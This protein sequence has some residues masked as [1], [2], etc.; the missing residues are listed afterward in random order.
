MKIFVLGVKISHHIYI[1]P[2]VMSF[3]NSTF[4]PFCVNGIVRVCLS[5]LL[6]WCESSISWV[7]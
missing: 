6:P 5:L 1:D 2:N 3:A 7:R 4:T